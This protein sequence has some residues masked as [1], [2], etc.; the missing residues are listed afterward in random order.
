MQPRSVLLSLLCLLLLVAL[1]CQ[2]AEEWVELFNGKDLTG[3]KNPFEWGKAEVVD[4][5]IH[6]TGDQKFFLVSEQDFDDFVLEGEVKLPSGPANSGFMFRCHVEPNRVYG[7]Q[8]EVDGSDRRWSG[9]I[10][11]EGRREWLWPSLTGRTKDEKFLKHE[12]ES[13][14]FFKKPEIAGALKRDDWN[15]YRITCQGDSLKV[16]VNDVLISDIHDDLDA[17]GPVGIQ[18]HGE[19]DAVYKFRNLRV[20]EL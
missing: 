14:E 9:G 10:Y 16:E 15:R 20:R 6:L 7:Y 11:D 4:G 2:A 18:H 13:H 17:R 5:E 12:K 19:K 3:W 8:A 1:P